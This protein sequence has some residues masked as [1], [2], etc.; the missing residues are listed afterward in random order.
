MFF[1]CFSAIDPN[2]TK[3]STCTTYIPSHATYI[4]QVADTNKYIKAH[5]IHEVMRKSQLFKERLDIGFDYFEG[6]PMDIFKTAI[7][8]FVS[9]VRVRGELPYDPSLIVDEFVNMHRPALH[10][11]TI[12]AQEL[13]KGLIEWVGNRSDVRFTYNAFKNHLVK[14]LGVK[15]RPCDIPGAGTHAV[16][17]FP[18]MIEMPKFVSK[19]HEFLEMEEEARGYKIM[20]VD[21][22]VTPLKHFADAFEDTM[23]GY[24]FEVEPDV[25]GKYGF[26][27]YIG[28][29]G[30]SKK[31]MILNMSMSKS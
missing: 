7:P 21:G 28:Q 24:Q 8:L 9:Q 2:I 11:A 26:D 5:D 30:D 4:F 23:E 25:L 12:K 19:V 6:D 15:Y 1:I 3:V 22:Y 27:V 18:P 20:Y 31:V 16:Y 13:F 14:S 17:Q 29:D 10:N